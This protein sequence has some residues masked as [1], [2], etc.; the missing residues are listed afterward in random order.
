[1]EIAQD[2]AAPP[3]AAATPAADS[4]ADEGKNEAE[5]SRQRNGRDDGDDRKERDRDRGGAKDN[6]KEKG[7]SGTKVDDPKKVDAAK[8]AGGTAT[9]GGPADKQ[10]HT[11][12]DLLREAGVDPNAK[13]KDDGPKLEKKSLNAGDIRKAMSALNGRAQGC[14]AKHHQSGSVAVRLTVEPSGKVT[15]SV[16]TGSFAG[17]PTGDCVADVAGNASF[18]AWDGKV[19]TVNYSY[20]L[21]E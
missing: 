10:E 5:N 18:P 6:A 9:G 8:G 12:D 13:P 15:K 14:Y 20:F 4:K 2:P 11:V 17:T 16:T 21:S 3:P 1:M 19:M 7:A